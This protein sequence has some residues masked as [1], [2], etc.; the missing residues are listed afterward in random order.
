MRSH[1]FIAAVALFASIEAFAANPQV[2]QFTRELAIDATG[3]IL[4]DN[5]YGSIDVVGTDDEKLGI[6][7]QRQITAMD[8]Q[9]L[10]DAREA[11]IIVFQGSVHGWVVKTRYPELRD[12]RWV[13]ICNY[14][15]R[16]PRGVNLKVGAKAMDHIRLTQLAGNVA[17]NAF[18]GTVIL[19]NVSGPSTVTTVNG[20]VIY[21]Y[22]QRPTADARVN[23]I[24][25]DIDIYAPRESSFEWVADSL[26]GDL[27]TTFDLRGLFMGN[28]F[29]GRSNNTPGAPTLSTSTVAG[30]VMLLARGTSPADAKRI[31][32][33]PPQGRSAAV[34]SVA[35][36]QTTLA[37][38]TPAVRRFQVPI[39]YLQKWEFVSNVADIAVREVHGSAHIETGAGEVELGVVF[40]PCEVISGGGPLNLGD[41][42]GPI[43]VHT[44]AGDVYVRMARQ[45]GSASTDG[46]LIRVNYAGGPMNLR[47]GGGDIAVLEAASSIDA[48][49]RSGDIGITMSPAMKTNHL[50]A[51]TSQGNIT[52]IVSPTFAADI[53]ATLVTDDSDANRIRSD[54]NLTVRREVANGKTRL[55]ATGKINGGGG[56]IELFA[57]DGSINISSQAIGSTALPRR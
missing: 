25:A 49:T 26:Q 29:R 45:G 4:L 36:E 27:L 28:T 41:M 22:A 43:D 31:V 37:T 13:A 52:L 11:V 34:A 7:V 20:R 35:A 56:R 9:A 39:I 32:A 16:V 12:P 54:F 42:R 30:R 44:D 21:D 8:D 10:K 47:S 51:K 55:H 2:D 53:D 23:A 6:T 3:T 57:E 14:F 40:G 17:V 33:V 48:S 5:A 19:S 46:G 1:F 24:N 15:V 50:T 18:S 38:N